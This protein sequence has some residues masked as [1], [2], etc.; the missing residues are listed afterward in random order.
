[1]LNRDAVSDLFGIEQSVPKFLEH[2]RQTFV[3]I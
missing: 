3:E 1:M 2:F